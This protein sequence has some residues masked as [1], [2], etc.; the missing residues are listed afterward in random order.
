MIA[1]PRKVTPLDWIISWLVSGIVP[2]IRHIA[3]SWLV[4]WRSC[5]S[6]VTKTS[7]V[8]VNSTVGIGGGVSEE[9][10]L[11]SGEAVG[12]MDGN[13]VSVFVGVHV[14][15][16]V[17]VGIS[18]V[19]VLN[20][21]SVGVCV[22][23]SVAVLVGVFASAVSVLCVFARSASNVR[24]DVVVQAAKIKIVKNIRYRKVSIRPTPFVRYAD[25]SI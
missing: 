25:Y 19:T 18:R 8:G 7:A 1:P 14:A 5:A 2:L 6:V 10:G 13:G 9:V 4:H 15:V 22:S 3:F 24:S 16:S 21:V 11:V 17:K 12:V 20:S 23:T